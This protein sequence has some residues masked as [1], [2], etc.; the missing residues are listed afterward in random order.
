MQRLLSGTLH[1]FALTL[2]LPLLPSTA[3]ASAND[4]GAITEGSMRALRDDGAPIPLPLEHTDVQAEISGFVSRV[5]VVQTFH[6]PFQERIEAIYVLPLPDKGAV[7]SMT[8]EVGQR[9]VRGVIKNREEARQLY[10]AAKNSGRTAALLDQERPNI[11]TQSVANILPG[12]RITVTLTYVAPL[13]YD[14]GQYTFNFPMVVGPRYIPG[15]PLGG[16]SQGTGTHADTDRV[17]D[18]SRIFPPLLPEGT[19]SGHDISLTVKLDAGVPIQKMECVSHDVEIIRSGTRRAEVRL[20]PS[21]AIPNKDFILRY[22]VAGDQLE[23]GILTHKDERGGFFTLML[24]PQADFRTSEITPKEMFFVIDQSCSQSGLPMEKQKGIIYEALDHMNPGDTFNIVSFNSGVNFFAPKALANTPENVARARR[25]VD[26][27]QANGGTEMLQGVLAC[28]DA[29]RDP[30]RLRMV[31]FLSD[32]YVGNDEEIIHAV[33]QHIG[34]ARMFTY[35]VGAS[36]NHYLLDRMAEVGRGDYQYARPDEDTKQS[37]A[38]FY[39]RISKPYLVDIELD[40]GDLGVEEVYPKRVRDLFAS[41]PIILTGHYGAGG[42]GKFTLKGRIAGKPYVEE[43]EV[44]LP[45]AAQPENEALASMFGRAK[46]EHLAGLQHGGEKPEIVKAITDTALRFR[47]MSAYTSFVAIDDVV[48]TGQGAPISVQ[49]PVPTPE[50][51]RYEAFAATGPRRAAAHGAAWS[52]VAASA[53][54]PAPT[55]AMPPPPPVPSRNAR[56]PARMIAA[57]A[58]EVDLPAKDVAL[59]VDEQKEAKPAEE[60]KRDSD[61]KKV[62]ALR[63]QVRELIIRG[64]M[65]RAAAQRQLQQALEQVAHRL[66]GRFEA[67]GDLTLSLT[68]GA[69]GTVTAIAVIHDGLHV[70]DLTTELRAVLKTIRFAANPS[71]SVVTVRISAG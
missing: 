37:V 58:K 20:K 16:Q 36:V 63:L 43:I 5:Q 10:E 54:V 53:S 39:D 26:G 65:T 8:M 46:I 56:A 66:A 61:V 22:D 49:Q 18:A 44:D 32:G 19:R 31:L 33:E 69:D 50:G 45:K 52:G 67:T 47:L 6:N 28:L 40:Y 25:F 7:D 9:T 24:Q 70:A 34:N 51:T 1:A 68:I 29:E 71:G 3:Y 13:E 64:P 30:Q 11:F 2:L 60:R 38:R 55:V 35:G 57:E 41:Q 15:T 14:H 4:P 23:A 42:H 59:D 27:L 62:R 48:R 12:E 17:P 21:D